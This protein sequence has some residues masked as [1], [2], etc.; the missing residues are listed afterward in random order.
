ME[1]NTVNTTNSTP[2]KRDYT[3]HRRSSVRV[4][5]DCGK[6]YVISDNDVMYYIK[7]FGSM[8]LRC[9]ECRKRVREANPWPVPIGNDSAD[10]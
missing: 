5:K 4:C 2:V 3:I 7:N 6:F 9:E 10:V 8:P 1:N